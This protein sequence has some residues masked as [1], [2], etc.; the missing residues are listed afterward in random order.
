MKAEDVLVV[1][2]TVVTDKPEAA[3]RAAEVFARAAAGL[4]LEGISVNVSL[5]KPSVEEVVE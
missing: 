4:V 3:V 5:G 1:S 2:A